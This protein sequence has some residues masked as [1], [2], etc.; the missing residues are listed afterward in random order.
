[1]VYVYHIFLIHSSVSRHLDCFCVLAI[2][3]IAAMNL[4]VHVPFQI[5]VFSGCL[6]PQVGLLDHVVVL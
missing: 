1:M 2:A 3:N 4:G 5:M 6:C